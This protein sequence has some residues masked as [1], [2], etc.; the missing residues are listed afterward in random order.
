MASNLKF[1]FVSN[2]SVQWLKAT[3]NDLNKI[4]PSVRMRITKKNVL[5]YTMK[6]KAALK[7][8][9]VPYSDVFQPNN[10]TFNMLDFI[11]L[12]SKN[13][14]QNLGFF[15]DEDGE[16]V[17]TLKAD[18]E[19]EAIPG[20]VVANDLQLSNGELTLKQ[21][22]GQNKEVEG[23]LTIEMLQQ[24]LDPEFA[25]HTVEFDPQKM[26]D[27]KRMSTLNNTDE[28]ILIRIKDEVM[29]FAQP[30]WEKRVAD[31]PGMGNDTFTFNRQY[32]N[33]IVP[34]TEPIRINFFDSYISLVEDNSY[35]M[36]GLEIDNF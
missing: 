9:I 15:R 31:V 14:A 17:M 10:D 28:T 7:C 25:N 5:M 6:G 35:F 34:G 16:A 30:K 11:F 22:S 12:N 29:Y 8:A 23:R 32:L 24:Q 33:S 36:I 26:I 18:L 21:I 19:R 27:I 13:M 2:E 1:K 4:N 3:L 20:V